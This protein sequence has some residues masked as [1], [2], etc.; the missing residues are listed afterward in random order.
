MTEPL[1]EFG[2]LSSKGQVAIP[3]RI[4]EKMGLKQGSRLVFRLEKDTLLVSV[5]VP[6]TFGKLTAPL[7]EAIKGTGLREEDAVDIVRRVRKRLS[8][9]GT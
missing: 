6:G 8:A 9:R 7:K 1:V 3:S 4:R 5:I 2:R